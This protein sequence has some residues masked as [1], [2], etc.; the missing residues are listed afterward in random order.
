MRANPTGRGCHPSFGTSPLQHRFGPPGER[1]PPGRA[2]KSGAAT[3]RPITNSLRLVI[4]SYLARRLVCILRLRKRDTHST[5]LLLLYG[6]PSMVRHPPIWSMCAPQR[7]L[8]LLVLFLRPAHSDLRTPTL[9]LLLGLLRCDRPK[10]MGLVTAPRM[11]LR[12]SIAGS[13]L[14]T[15][16]PH[17]SSV[18]P[19]RHPSRYKVSLSLFPLTSTSIGI[20]PSH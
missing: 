16:A 18:L 17:L 4:C 8:L 3:R 2:R 14:A 6:P 19:T 15:T 12:P 11:G 20:G 10:S 7:S 9:R 1:G 13:I 5:L